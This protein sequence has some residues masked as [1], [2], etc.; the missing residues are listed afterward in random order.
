MSKD[1]ETDIEKLES[2]LSKLGDVMNVYEEILVI[3]YE[4]ITLKFDFDDDGV[5]EHIRIIC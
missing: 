1:K 4:N 2:I 5:L 3:T